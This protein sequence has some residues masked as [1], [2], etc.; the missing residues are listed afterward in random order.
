MKFWIAFSMALA[1]GCGMHT[2]LSSFGQIPRWRTDRIR[3]ALCKTG[4][5]VL[6]RPWPLLQRYIQHVSPLL[7]EI[8]R[9]FS[10]DCRLFLLSHLFAGAIPYL[11]LKHQQKRWHRALLKALPDYLELQALVMEAGLDLTAG[12]KHYLEKGAASPLKPLLRGLQADIQRGTS[13][14][15]AY[16]ALAERSSFPPLRA[17]CRSIAQAFVLGTPLAPLL[18]EHAQDLRLRRMQL[19]EKRA[20]EAPIRML[21]PLFVFIFPTL[22]I[23]LLG[24][25]A[26][27]FMKGFE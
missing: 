9:P 27:L 25:L 11:W 16:Q 3:L 10:G 21:F 22:F 12:L 7:K 23:V 14:R 17:V 19:A 13:R 8:G 5:F 24:P 2:T 18:R 1:I 20:A 6:A 15:E 26:M 4:D